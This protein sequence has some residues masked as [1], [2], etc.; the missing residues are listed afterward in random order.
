M[1]WLTLAL[2]FGSKLMDKLPDYDQKKRADFY[3]LKSEY[4]QLLSAPYEERDDDK[5][6]YQ[7]EKLAAFMQA[8]NKEIEGE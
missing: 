7:K 6:L 1:E 4:F 5:I 3:K 2:A 8:F